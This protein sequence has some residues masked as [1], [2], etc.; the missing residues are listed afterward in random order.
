MER[1]RV[2]VV[3][4]EQTVQYVL[5]TL[6]REEGYETEAAGSAEEALTKLE[7]GPIA[8]AFLDIVLP[9]MNGISLLERIKERDPDAEVIVMTSQSSAKTAI[10]ALRKGAYAACLWG[11]ESPG[12]WPW[13]GSSSTR[14]AP[15]QARRRRPGAIPAATGPSPPSRFP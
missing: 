15:R 4:D 13:R 14:T 6:L 8:V 2:L 1:T 7:R 5:T 10:E 12:A 9:G 11:R 3:D